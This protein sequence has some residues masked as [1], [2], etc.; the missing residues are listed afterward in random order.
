MTTKPVNPISR[1]HYL[2]MLRT[3]KTTTQKTTTHY[4]QFVELDDFVAAPALH[5][6]AFIQQLFNLEKLV[7]PLPRTHLAETDVFATFE[8]LLCRTPNFLRSGKQRDRWC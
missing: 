5:Y 3:L 6:T 1:K 4:L 2:Q 7:Q 8:V